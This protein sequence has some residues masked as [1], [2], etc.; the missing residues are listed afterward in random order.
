MVPNAKEPLRVP[1]D[2]RAKVI[3]LGN[4]LPVLWENP[5]T[6]R[7][8]RKAL[9]RCLIEKVVMH[10]CAPDKAD[11][12]IVWRG[13]ATTEFTVSLPVNAVAA[14]PRHPEMFAH[15]C[16][17]QEGLYDEE[18]ARILTQEGHHSP[19]ETDKVLPSYGPAHS[20]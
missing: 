17:G 12:R 2:L 5:A 18:I 8:H 11:V 3:A 9:L 4:R 16:I 13:G 10:R 14:L 19:W 6:R 7:D 15:L 1:Q 20:P